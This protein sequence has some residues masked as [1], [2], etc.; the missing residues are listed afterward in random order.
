MINSR[1]PYIPRLKLWLNERF[2]IINFVSGV[3]I[4]LL[5]KSVSGRL[6]GV[7]QLGFTKE[8]AASLVP[9]MHLFLLRVFDEHKD[10]ESDKINYPDRILQKGIF[11]LSEIRRLGW[12][13][14][15]IEVVSFGFVFYISSWDLSVLGLFIF[16]WVWTGLMTKEFFA[17]NWLKGRFL[18][19]GFSHLLI[20]PILFLSCISLA[21]PKFSWSAPVLL[22]L[23][24]SLLT[25]W[26]YEVTRKTK[27]PEEE[28]THD[29]SYSQIFGIKTSLVVIALS[30]L[31]THIVIWLLFRELD[32]SFWVY[33]FFGLPLLFISLFSLYT[34]YKVPTPKNRKKNEQ[35]VGLAALFA[36]LIPIVCWLWR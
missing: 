21:N 12:F 3:F 9:M 22:S 29:K 13:S 28:K 1:M 34:F 24:L 6:A 25:G 32:I 15:L 23:L 35:A 10:F 36:Y 31:S 20:T 26:L 19:Y 27:A 30:L 7:S 8:I 4:Y 18:L 5:A 2:P 16:L 14:F 11:T 33:G 17:R